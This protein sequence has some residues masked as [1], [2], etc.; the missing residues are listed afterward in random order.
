MPLEPFSRL[1]SS[2]AVSTSPRARTA[3][4]RADLESL[5]RTRQ[6]DRTLTTAL[7]LA[8]PSQ[9]PDASAATGV[10]ALDARLGGGL[11]RGQISELVGPRSSG[12]TSLMLQMLTAATARGEIVALVD[13]LDTLDVESAAEAGIDLDRLLWVRGHVVP[14]PG[15][16]RDMNQRAMEQAVRALALILQAGNFGLVVFDVADAPADAVRR[17]PF[18]TWLRLQRIVEGSQTTCL[19]VGSEAMARSAAGLSLRTRAGIRDQR[20]GIREITESTG[21]RFGN[22]LFEGLDIETRVVRARIRAH[23]DATVAVRTIAANCA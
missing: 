5:L 4:A 20:L 14:N 15:L 10:D 8:T 18:T 13:A 9:D 7:P 11:P 6:L 17:L 1:E 2:L 22:R 19:L 21:V 12:R 16:C 3:L 23:E